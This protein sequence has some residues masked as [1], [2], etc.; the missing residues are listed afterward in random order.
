MKKQMQKFTAG[1]LLLALLIGLSACGKKVDVVGSW[2]NK[3]GRCLSVRSDGSY[4]VEDAYG[5]GQWAY[6][7]NGN[8]KFTDIY[9]VVSETPITKDSVGTHLT[10]KEYGTFY[11][12]EYPAEKIEQQKE[13]KSADDIENAQL[14]DV[15]KIVKLTDFSNGVAVVSYEDSNGDKYQAMINE[16][17]KPIYQAEY[18]PNCKVVDGIAFFYTTAINGIDKQV[19]VDS[20]GKVIAELGDSRFDRIIGTAAGYTFVYKHEADFDSN[21]H[22]CAAMD[23]DGKIVTE[24]VECPFAPTDYRDVKAVGNDTFVIYDGHNAYSMLF[25]LKT[26]KTYKMRDIDHPEDL[27][28][29]N[30]FTYVQTGSWGEIKKI[31]KDF[32]DEIVTI[33]NLG[34]ATISNGS[35]IYTTGYDSEKGKYI[36]RQNQK[37][38][39]RIDTTGSVDLLHGYILLSMRGADGHTY[40]TIADENGNQ[41]FAPVRCFRITGDYTKRFF[42]EDNFVLQT[43]ENVWQAYK[44]D[45]T[46]YGKGVFENIEFNGAFHDGIA[47]VKVD[48]AFHYMDMNGNILI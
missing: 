28:F 34:S 27:Y 10:I 46:P 14:S 45:G 4:T 17:M 21:R 8:V 25:N 31:T 37:S 41:K 30:G 40:F 9:G 15:Q 20:E 7:D 32:Q 42:S 12:N 16:E 13:A 33:D 2:Y 43:D 26:G 38:P 23:R 3:E 35:L 39:L 22:L 18:I 48:D 36:L 29:I 6:L 47:V 44:L 1:L 11:L 24:W 5:E 19:D